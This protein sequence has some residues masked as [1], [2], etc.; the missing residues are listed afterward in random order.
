[1]TEDK[2]TAEAKQETV[3]LTVNRLNTT[4]LSILCSYHLETRPETREIIKELLAED[5]KS[6]KE[7]M[8]AN[9]AR[10][11][12]L[13]WNTLIC[14]VKSLTDLDD[15]KTKEFLERKKLEFEAES[16]EIEDSC[17]KLATSTAECYID[18]LGE[19]TVAKV[20]VH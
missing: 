5:F 7:G 17:L 20:L 18:L 3:K 16:N 8:L 15:P 4:L 14:S 11:K 6:F 10:N 12:E 19:S 1:M 13:A 2:I 9:M